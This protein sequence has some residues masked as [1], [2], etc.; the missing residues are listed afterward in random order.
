MD[1][2]LLKHRLQDIGGADH[3]PLGGFLKPV[4]MTFR[5]CCRI[6]PDPFLDVIIICGVEDRLLVRDG[7]ESFIFIV[8]GKS[9]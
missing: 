2:G 9:G 1:S 7:I 6:L 4:P 5:R 8:L 3:V